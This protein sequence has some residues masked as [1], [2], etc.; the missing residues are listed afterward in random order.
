MDLNPTYRIEHRRFPRDDLPV[1]ANRLGN[2]GFAPSTFAFR[3]VL[4]KEPVA[5]SS[6]VP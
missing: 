2:F 6:V 1:I 5:Q 4:P 3:R